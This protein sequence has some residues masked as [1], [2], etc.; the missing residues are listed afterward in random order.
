MQNYYNLLYREEE[1]E[2]IPYCRD[3]GVGCI[4]V[5]NLP[6]RHTTFPGADL[7]ATQWSPNA[8]GVLARPWDDV[9]KSTSLRSQ[10]DATLSR[11]Y[12]RENLVD[13]ATVDMVEEIASARELPMAVIATAWCL[14]KGVNPIVGLN[15]KERI[16]EAVLAASVELTED[17]ITRLESAYQPK[18]VTGY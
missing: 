17:E 12:S 7:S 8:R 18:A 15:S 1:R 10:H 6:D 9:K 16:D 13:R 2:M 14:S 3:T 4:P 11:L 5:S